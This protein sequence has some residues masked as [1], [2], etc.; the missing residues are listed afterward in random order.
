[1]LIIIIAYGLS[2][3][4]TSFQYESKTAIIIYGFWNCFA[5][6]FMMLQSEWFLNG[7][8]TKKKKN[9]EENS[10]L[11]SKSSCLVWRFSVL[12]CNIFPMAAAHTWE[13]TND[14]RMRFEMF[15]C[16]KFNKCLL[17][18]QFLCVCKGAYDSL[19][20]MIM[21]NGYDNDSLN[22]MEDK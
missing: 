1:M 21:K 2:Q 3:L 13:S 18:Q 5:I 9:K 14:R 8:I 15:Y 22:Q 12:S 19:V 17:N 10:N 6:I 7:R 4:K 11:N 20:M 16:S